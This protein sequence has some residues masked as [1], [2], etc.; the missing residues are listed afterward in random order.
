MSIAGVEPLRGRLVPHL[1]VRDTARAVAYYD[2]AFGATILYKGPL[3]GSDQDHYQL[4]IRDNVLL[5]SAEPASGGGPGNIASPETLGGTSVVLTLFVDDAR[6]A[7]DRAVKAGGKSVIPPMKS[8]WGDLFAW[9]RD[10]DG[11]I[12]QMSE[13]LEVV[14]PNAVDAGRRDFE[15]ITGGL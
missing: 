10:H 11:H 9:V 4:R 7:H 1:I 15:S 14:V 12:W 8:Y 6:A 5:V 2:L 13:I 3:P